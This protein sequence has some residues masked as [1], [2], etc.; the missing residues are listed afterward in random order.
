MPISD[1][2]FRRSGAMALGEGVM[3]AQSPRLYRAARV[4]GSRRANAKGTASM[5]RALLGGGEVRP[6]VVL[7]A[8]DLARIE[9]PVLMLWGTHDVFLTPA[10]AR[11]SIEAIPNAVLETCD[12]GHGPWLEHPDWARA[13]IADFLGAPSRQ[14]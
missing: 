12:A 11:L 4:A 8:D 14:I 5:F 6:G 3:E 13:L 10:N 2:Q 7:T 9:Q 1:K